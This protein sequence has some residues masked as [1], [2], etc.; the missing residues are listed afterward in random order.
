MTKES[1]NRVMAVFTVAV[2]LFLFAASYVRVGERIPTHA[3]ALPQ[4][5]AE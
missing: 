4:H 3:S 1:F 5:V 2:I